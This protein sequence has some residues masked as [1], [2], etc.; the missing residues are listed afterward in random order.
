M[1]SELLRQDP[2]NAFARYGLALEFRNRGD[3]ARALEEFHKLLAASPGYVPAYQM[4]AD[5]LL[6]ANQADAAKSMLRDGIRAASRAGDAHA[7]SEMQGM[8]DELL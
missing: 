7:E 4:A 6:K 1:L 3:L 5:T 8:L 2:G